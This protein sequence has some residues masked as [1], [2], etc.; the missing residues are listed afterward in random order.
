[1]KTCTFEQAQRHYENMSP[2]EEP[3]ARVCPVCSEE[4]VYATR[5]CGK[6]GHI[7][8]WETKCRNC[9]DKQSGDNFE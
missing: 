3:E 7:Y 5:N 1:M 4:A 9:G 6:K 8:W 2:P